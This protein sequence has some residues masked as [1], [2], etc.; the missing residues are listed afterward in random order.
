MLSLHSRRGLSNETVQT[1]RG[2]SIEL[3][4]NGAPERTVRSALGASIGMPRPDSAL[5]DEV[6]AMLKERCC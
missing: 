4:R 6:G 1:A 3:N 2:F 5:F